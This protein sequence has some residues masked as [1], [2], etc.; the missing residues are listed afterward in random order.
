MTSA[1]ELFKAAKVEQGGEGPMGSTIGRTERALPRVLLACMCTCALA[2]LSFFL[3]FGAP[4]E[5]VCAVGLY[6][7]PLFIQCDSYA[8]N[9][10]PFLLA[11]SFFFLLRFVLLPF[12]RPFLSPFRVLPLSL[13]LSLS[14]FI[15][16]LMSGLLV[17]S[18]K[19]RKL[20][21]ARP[22]ASLVR[23]LMRY[24]FE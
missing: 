16:S 1:I 7:R 14:S 10:S 13:S 6:P 9:P 8:L 19:R 21:Y 15:P 2:L 5:Q 4:Q 17:D 24:S 22:L 18:E 23:K 20:F 11:F 12:H 3:A